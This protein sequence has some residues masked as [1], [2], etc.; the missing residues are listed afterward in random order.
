[1]SANEILSNHLIDEQLV[2][3]DFELRKSDNVH[4]FER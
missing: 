1:M 3:C 2:D 4:I